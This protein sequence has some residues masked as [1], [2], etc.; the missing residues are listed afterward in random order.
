MPFG[1]RN[2][3]IFA[4][5][6]GVRNFSGVQPIAPTRG[7]PPD[8]GRWKGVKLGRWDHSWLLIHELGA[9]DYDAEM[10]DRRIK[11]LGTHYDQPISLP[12]GQGV[13]QSWRAFLTDLY[14]NELSELQ[15]IGADRV[16]FG[17]T[18]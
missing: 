11:Q 9:F 16:V 13:R 8:A 4:F 18:G 12:P 3:S 10:E 15:R 6:A 17:F 2:Y 5:L 7:L 14:F 1:G